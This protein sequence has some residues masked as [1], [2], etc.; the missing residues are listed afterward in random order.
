MGPL[1]CA[2]GQIVRFTDDPAVA[3]GSGSSCGDGGAGGAVGNN[4]APCMSSSKTIT[5]ESS[6][7]FSS[8]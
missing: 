4:K 8:R 7:T 5:F 6:Q 2:A 1:Y 3:I